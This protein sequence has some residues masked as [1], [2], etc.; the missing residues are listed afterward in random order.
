[1]LPDASVVYDRPYFN[2]ITFMGAGIYH[3]TGNLYY[4]YFAWTYCVA[5]TTA[6]PTIRETK[7]V[8]WWGKFNNTI[9]SASLLQQ[10]CL[11]AIATDRSLSVY[12]TTGFSYGWMSNTNV[13]NP[14]L[15]VLYSDVYQGQNVGRT[16]YVI[17]DITNPGATFDQMEVMWDIGDSNFVTYKNANDAIGK[18]PINAFSYHEV[19]GG[20][21]SYLYLDEVVLSHSYTSTLSYSPLDNPLLTNKSYSFTYTIYNNN[22]LDISGKKYKI[23]IDGLEQKS[24]NLN[25]VGQA[26]FSLTILN[27]SAHTFEIRI[28]DSG[29]NVIYGSDVTGYVFR[30]AVITPGTIPGEDI[31]TGLYALLTVWVPIGLVVMIPT[32]A[33]ALLG[34][35]FGVTGMMVGML[36]GMFLGVLGGVLV[37]ILPAYALYLYILV[38]GICFTIVARSGN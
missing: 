13:T 18:N 5:P 24:G 25:S 29:N 16:M 32:L 21:S 19:I 2:M 8:Y 35:K 34:S 7:T 38:M 23:L 4:M 31:A 27:P 14:I 20:A 22:V 33:L 17:Y 30:D 12:S 6:S 15:N 1:M 11:S 9:N 28:L 3:P 37:N 26:T 10:K 36:M